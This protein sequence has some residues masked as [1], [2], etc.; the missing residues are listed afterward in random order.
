[1]TDFPSNIV[2]VTQNYLQAP[3]CYHKY[4]LP[5]YGV[6]TKNTLLV[7]AKILALQML[8]LVPILGGQ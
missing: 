7:Q 6:H 8:I 4:S 5:A 1:M 2:A 3:L